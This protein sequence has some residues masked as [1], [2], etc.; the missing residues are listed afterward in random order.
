MTRLPRSAIPDDGGFALIGYAHGCD[1]HS[2]GAGLR[3]RLLNN[4]LGVGPD[5]ECVVL[6]PTGLWEDLLVLELIAA[7]DLA[8]MIEQHA[9][10]TGRTLVDGGNVS[11]HNSRTRSATHSLACPSAPLSHFTDRIAPCS[12][13]E[14]RRAPR[15]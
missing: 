2:G 8:G 9:T 13:Q 6:Y 3:E 7:S 10:S 1:V 11:S 4:L 5:F 12:R 15:R 14:F